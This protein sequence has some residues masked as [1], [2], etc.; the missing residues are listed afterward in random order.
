MHKK[1]I[2]YG[3]LLQLMI[4]LICVIVSIFVIIEISVI[5]QQEYAFTA[6]SVRKCIIIKQKSICKANLGWIFACNYEGT[7]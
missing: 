3:A 4:Y 2:I 6:D 7:E 5:I 1:E